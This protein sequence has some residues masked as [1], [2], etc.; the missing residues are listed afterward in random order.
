MVTVSFNLGAQGFRGSEFILW[1][2]FLCLHC[3]DWPFLKLANVKRQGQFLEESEGP[4]LASTEEYKRVALV[5]IQTLAKSP[6]RV[7]RHLDYDQYRS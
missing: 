7:H 6:H 5:S 3:G 4:A 1:H 2:H